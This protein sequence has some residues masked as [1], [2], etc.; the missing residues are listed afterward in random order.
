M[1]FVWSH[2]RERAMMCNAYERHGEAGGGSGQRVRLR[3]LSC[4][5]G[6]WALGTVPIREQIQNPKGHTPGGAQHTCGCPSQHTS[7]H[8]PLTLV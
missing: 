3:E 6:V 4:A 2:D 5:L 8:L 1:E 7:I